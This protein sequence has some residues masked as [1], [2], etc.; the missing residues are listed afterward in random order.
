MYSKFVCAAVLMLAAVGIQFSAH[1]VNVTFTSASFGGAVDNDG[2][3]FAQTAN[4]N[5]NESTTAPTT[6]YENI[7]YRPTGTVTWLFFETTSVHAVSGASNAYFVTINGGSHGQ[8]DWGIEVRDSGTGFLYNTITSGNLA[9]YGMELASEDVPAPVITSSLTK[10]GAVGTAFS[11]Q[12]TAINSPTSFN[13]VVAGRT[14]LP[15]GLSI[16]PATGVISGT[17]I[18]F[19]KFSI[20][21]TAANGG[22]SGNATLNLDIHYPAHGA[23]GLPFYFYFYPTDNTGAG[24]IS[25]TTLPAGLSLAPLDP[26]YAQQLVGKPVAAAIFGLPTTAGFTSVTFTGMFTTETISATIDITIDPAPAP[27]S[28][29]TGITIS[30]DPVRVN[31]DVTFTAVSQQLAQGAQ[32][33]FVFLQGSQVLPD[34]VQVPTTFGSG[35]VTRQF[36]TPG[37]YTAFSAVFDGFNVG[38]YTQNFTVEALDPLSQVASVA[39]GTITNPNNGLG[40]SVPTSLGGVLDFDIV[41]NGTGAAVRDDTVVNDITGRSAVQGIVVGKNRKNFASKFSD[42]GIYVIKTNVNGRIARRMLPIG[43]PE[44]GQPLSVAAPRD[45]SAGIPGRTTVSGKF[46]LT[47]AKSDQVK[48]S[49]TITLPAGIDTT[50]PQTLDLGIGNVVETVTLTKGNGVSSDGK[51][52][53]QLKAAKKGPAKFTITLTSPQLDTLGFDTEGISATPKAALNIQL[54]FVIEGV[55]YF[56]SVPVSAKATKGK[57]TTV[58]ISGK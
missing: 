12:I 7:Y 18:E 49:G 35:A 48:L 52:K 21:L 10:A 14:V 40:I 44:V 19:G 51:V 17:P 42:S 26:T 47:P 4:L 56:K 33:V 23:V 9:A 11:Y 41:D 38:F 34:G 54:A 57:A 50:V 20:T 22:G 53:L 37:D 58:Q 27:S 16:N 39:S 28:L 45:D 43:K 2:D 6:V 13:A 32:A 30:R 55:P 46:F 15:F 1:A 24:P 8:Y 29:I 36:S 31:T 5:W 3:G 25:S